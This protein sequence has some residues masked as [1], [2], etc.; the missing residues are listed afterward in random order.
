MY[1]DRTRRAMI[2]AICLIAAALVMGWFVGRYIP[3]EPGVPEPKPTEGLFLGSGRMADEIVDFEKG[4]TVELPPVVRGLAYDYEPEQT[5]TIPPRSIEHYKERGEWEY[6]CPSIKI[7][8]SELRSVDSSA[9]FDWYIES[10]MYNERIYPE[11][12]IMAAVTLTIENTSD[13]TIADWRHLPKF[14]LW[15]DDLAYIDTSMGSGVEM[16]G[17]FFEINPGRMAPEATEHDPVTTIYLEPGETQKLT[18]PFM[19]N[20]NN[21]KNQNNFNNLDLSRFCLQ[22]SDYGT[23]TTYRLWL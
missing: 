7:S 21:L 9:F 18:L 22:T 5:R 8:V 14:V 23:A 15:S 1:A 11:T 10:R 2:G 6:E 4:S 12:S 20:K 3:G 16:H 13:E 17:S 19:I